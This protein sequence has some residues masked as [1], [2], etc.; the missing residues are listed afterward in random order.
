MCPLDGAVFILLIL[1]RHFYLVKTPTNITLDSNLHIYTKNLM[2]ANVNQNM[3]ISLTFQ[4]HTLLR[5][6]S[7]G[8]MFKEI[9]VQSRCTFS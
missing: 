3:F 5:A 9:K 4:A 1:W 2:S 6:P 7:E 8:S